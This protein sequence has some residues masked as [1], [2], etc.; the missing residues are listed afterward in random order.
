M[1]SATAAVVAVAATGV[2][3]A[4]NV[5]NDVVAGGNDTITAGDSTTVNYRIS[6]T[7]GGN[8]GQNGCNA[9]DGTSATVSINAPA[10]VTASP[11]S[12]TF[13]DC[14]VAN[15]K[16]VVFS[17][18]TPGQYTITVSV[19]D[20]G[21]TVTVGTY[22]TAQATFTLEVNPV[23]D[24]CA[25]VSAPAAAVISASPS[26]PDGS[27]GWYTSV[28]TVSASS[29]TSGA[30][31]SYATEV[32]GGA[33][34][35]YSATGPTLGEGTTVVHARATSATCE[36]TSESSATYKVD[37][38]A[39]SVT[40]ANVTNVTWRN[41]PL[42]QEFTA[43]DVTSGVAGAN[44][45]TVT[46]SDES[47]AS[48]TPTVASHTFSDV[49]GNSTLRSVSALIDLT[50][51]S[52]TVTGVSDGA[53]YTL[54][55]VPAAGCGTSDA[56]SGVKTAASLSLSGG[57]VGSVT[58]TCSGAEDDA[59]NASSSA[60]VTY[61]VVYNWTGFFRPIDNGAVLNSVKAG[62]AVPVKFSLA[63][64]Q[65]LSIF[66]AGFPASQKIT[67]DSSATVDPIES[68]VTAGGSS[69]SYD[70]VADQYN[71]VWKTDKAWAGTCRQLTVKLI[72]GTVHT[73]QFK[74]L[75]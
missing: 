5:Q 56:L 15:E 67:C 43:R 38:V 50:V 61:S 37:T 52:V 36:K 13:S 72:D 47:A 59:G 10:A 71:Y 65:G 48:S 74:L 26:S 62:S 27:A 28:P 60:S 22:N 1:A 2:A 23:A 46:A 30:T 31:V 57:P 34:S 51:P 66:A 12:L 70:P 4:D 49:A 40:P 64:D 24:P 3:L 33:K 6:A 53:T 25:S 44:P 8:D 54:G 32:N 21:S 20:A 75:K 55:S 11:T 29:T 17:A 73:A 68:T 63:G 9:A 14:G 7:G 42:S 58:A 19:A 45:V 41:T 69:L 16:S 18:S 35:A 39:P